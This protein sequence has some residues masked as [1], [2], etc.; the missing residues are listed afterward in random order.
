MRT[1]RPGEGGQLRTGGTVALFVALA[2]ILAPSAA[3]KVTL[4]W[5]YVPTGL[6]AALAAKAGGALYLPARTPL[7]YRY[8]SGA[9][10]RGS[11]LTVAFVD[12][13]RVRQ[14]VWRWTN[15]QFLWQ[16]RPLPRNTMCK[17][18]GAGS[19]KTLQMDG[20]R[21]YWAQ[22]A[23]GVG[24]AWRCVTDRMHRTQLLIASDPSGRL[25]DVALAR[26]VASGL[27]VG[28]RR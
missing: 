28:G 7:F 24:K 12:R 22:D 2:A 5:S 1:A 11:L 3:A 6:R 4:A 13:V 18:W 19:Q 10:V 26:V 14:G 23:N 21:V 25:P 27:D 17:V 16:V 20:N 8:R 9:T 15:K